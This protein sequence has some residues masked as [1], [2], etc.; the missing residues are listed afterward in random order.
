MVGVCRENKR[1]KKRV[2]EIKKKNFVQLH[3][4]EHCPDL[5]RWRSC[6]L[7]RDIK[8]EAKN[9]LAAEL[10]EVL[11][12]IHGGGVAHQVE[13]DVLESAGV[14]VGQHEAVTVSLE[15]KGKSQG[16]KEKQ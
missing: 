16:K 8:K 15:N 14:S 4:P 6:L 2:G 11:Q 5:C 12:V 1:E 7:H 13:Q 3:N 9:V 10:T